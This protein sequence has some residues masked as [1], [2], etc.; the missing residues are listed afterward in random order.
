MI[1]RSYSIV[2]NDNFYSEEALRGI[3]KQRIH[4]A[5]KRSKRRNLPCSITVDDLM[6]LYKHQKGLCYL[7]GQRMCLEP[8]NYCT[9]SLDRIDPR[10]GYVLNNVGLVTWGSNQ[11]KGSIP[12]N[13]FYKWCSLISDNSMVA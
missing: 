11:M 12:L 3:F 6:V 8:H 10:K 13:E 7:S 4:D 2:T 1:N 9:L 5:R